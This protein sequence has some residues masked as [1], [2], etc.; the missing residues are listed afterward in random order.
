MQSKDL[1]GAS[2]A[3]KDVELLARAAFTWV[4]QQAMEQRFLGLP[5]TVAE[6]AELAAGFLAGI[7]SSL[8]RADSESILVAY[9]YVLMRGERASAVQSARELVSRSPGVAASCS[10]FLHGLSAARS[11]LT[12]SHASHIPDNL[13]V[14]KTLNESN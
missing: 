14:T 10:G 7:R 6:E 12:E 5:V 8:G 4:R 3:L 11:I 2:Q 9:S 1:D 13:Q